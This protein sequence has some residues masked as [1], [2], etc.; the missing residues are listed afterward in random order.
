MPFRGGEGSHH[1]DPSTPGV[2]V[3]HPSDPI[4]PYDSLVG[5]TSQQ[6]FPTPDDFSLESAH[7]QLCH[8]TP[9][10]CFTLTLTLTLTPPSSSPRVKLYRSPRLSFSPFPPSRL[11]PFPHNHTPFVV[12]VP[13]EFR[14]VSLPCACPS[15]CPLLLLPVALGPLPLAF[16]SAGRPRTRRPFRQVHGGASTRSCS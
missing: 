12:C 4:L 13:L 1:L 5:S 8:S 2:A 7:P 10:Q 3:S 11:S 9:N 14:F 16:P 15:A 6:R